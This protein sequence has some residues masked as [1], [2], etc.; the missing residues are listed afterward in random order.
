MSIQDQISRLE[1]AIAAQEMLRPTVGESVVQAAVEVLRDQLAAL[2][3]QEAASA[4]VQTGFTPEQALARLQEHIP[5]ALIEKARASGRVAGER[6]QV[7]VL[8]A[9]LSGF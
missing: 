1:A 3:R 8:F 7:T 5:E 4:G 6:K 2:H 9:D